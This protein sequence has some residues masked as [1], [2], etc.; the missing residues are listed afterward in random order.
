MMKCACKVVPIDLLD[1][2][3]LVQ[4]MQNTVQELIVRERKKP[5]G[6]ETKGL[7]LHIK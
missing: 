4:I 6:K 3:H 5:N 2:T 1:A 7:N